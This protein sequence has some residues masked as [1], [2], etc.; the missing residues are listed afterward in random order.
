AG[1]SSTPAPRPGAS[2]E[3]AR[4]RRRWR[5]SRP[6]HPAPSA[7][8]TRRAA[9]TSTGPRSATAPRGATPRG[10]PRAA[11]PRPSRPVPRSACND[12]DAPL[13]EDLVGRR[14]G[15]AVRALADDL[16]LDVGRVLTGDDVLGRGRYQ[17]VALHGQEL[18]LV[19]RLAP[20][21]PGEL[22][23]LPH[24]V[25]HVGHVETARLVDRPRLVGHRDDDG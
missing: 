4:R 25:E 23:P 14:R 11:A 12:E 17:H 1:K 16:G 22:A 13:L 24:P 21:I 15:G 9:P 20:R 19:E 3:T 18:V 2:P 10:W 6:G 7:P 8:S 5:T